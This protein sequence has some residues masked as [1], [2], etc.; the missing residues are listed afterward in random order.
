MPGPE[1]RTATRTPPVWFCS[2]HFVEGDRI[3]AIEAGDVGAPEG[4]RVHRLRRP[5]GHAWPDRRALAYDLRR[6]AS[7]Q[8]AFRRDGLHLSRRQRRGRTHAHARV[9][10]GPRSRRTVLR[11]QAGDRRRS[12]SRPAHLSLRRD[13]HHH[14]R[15]W[16][17]AGSRS[18]AL[19]RF[20]LLAERGFTSPHKRGKLSPAAAGSARPMRS[21]RAAAAARPRRRP[22][23]RCWSRRRAP[24][25]C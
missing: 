10:H 16:K 3:K 4:A 6:S 24:R 7:L 14:R 11:P 9:H 5:D 15:A 20:A 23:C 17:V 1:S 25:Q 19:P 12:G 8:P 13:D 18:C 2:D 21:I 22:N